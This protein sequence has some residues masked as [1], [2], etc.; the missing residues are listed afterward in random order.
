MRNFLLLAVLLICSSA[1]NAQQ[2]IAAE[3]Q[4]KIDRAKPGQLFPIW[5]LIQDQLD[6]AVWEAKFRDEKTSNSARTLQVINALKAQAAQSQTPIIAVIRKFAVAKGLKAYYVANLVAVQAPSSLIQALDQLPGI[7][8]IQSIP[9]DEL[10]PYEISRTKARKVSGVENGLNKIQAPFMWSLGYTGYGRKAFI[11]DTGTDPYHPALQEQY[12]GNQVPDA[13]AFYAKTKVP[14]PYDCDAHGSHV[15]GTIMGLDPVTHDTIGVAFEAKWMASPSLRVCLTNIGVDTTTSSLVD[16]FEWALDPDNNPNTIDDMPDAINN[17]WHNPFVPDGCEN[18]YKYVFNSLELA[19]VAVVFA[20][21]NEGPNAGTVTKPAMINTDLTNTFAVGALDG[22][23]DALPIADFSSHG[24]SPCPSNDLSLQIKPEVSAP[25][26]DVRSSIPGG[27]YDFYSGTSMASPHVCGAVV[28]LKQAFPDLPGSI[29]KEALYF[30]AL[31]LGVVGEDNTFGMGIIQLDKAY[32]YLIDHGNV[33][34]VI[35]AAQVD[36]QTFR[37]ASPQTTCNT[38]PRAELTIGNLGKGSV[39]C[40]IEWTLKEGDQILA[41]STEAAF[42]FEP[43]IMHFE[44]QFA[45][46]PPAI[47][48]LEA[49]LIVDDATDDRP[50]NNIIRTQI[51]IQPFEPINGEIYANP[52]GSICTTGSIALEVKPTDGISYVDWYNAP[53]AGTKLNSGN[54]ALFPV[55]TTAQTYYAEAHYKKFVGPDINS[56]GIT[57]YGNDS[58]GI[59]FHTHQAL[60][61][62]SVDIEVEATGIRSIILYR[63]AGKAVLNIKPILGLKVGINK[64]D[65]GFSLPD[66]GAYVLLLSSGKGLKF[67]TESVFPYSISDI[68]TMDNSIVKDQV[69]QQ[70]RYFYNWA[71]DYANPCGRAAYVVPAM[72]NSGNLLEMQISPPVGPYYPGSVLH[73]DAASD[74]SEYNWNLGDNSDEQGPFVTHSYSTTGN[75]P[76][77]L[78]RTQDS[79]VT[80]IQQNVLIEVNTGIKI[81]DNADIKVYPNPVADLL[82]VSGLPEGEKLLSWSMTN[83]LG[84]CLDKGQTAIKDQLLMI[85]TETLAPGFYV[86]NL[87]L[88]DSQYSVSFVK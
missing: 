73:F 3:L 12:W 78:C 60:I 16:A 20:N 85:G 50:L 28:L 13:Q 82:F 47:Y 11:I 86:L 38:H 8:Q 46:Y 66:T 49:K 87:L 43:G 41:N 54:P 35:V 72:Q 71:V 61:I 88:G 52:Q 62:K 37:L 17:S 57:E 68:L 33:A 23:K 10:T 44:Y 4:E 27:Q 24:P 65:L 51:N 79:C 64:V 76:V 15:T 63:K 18:G 80:C 19:G 36:V 34:Q 81:L 22:N 59:S 6:Y 14:F 9:T 40:H 77:I 58:A 29:I 32:Q 31:D 25:G 2:H 53:I 39:N 30:S 7:R 83:T 5:I 74:G 26:V 56:V 48:V 75:Y 84:Q 67:H 55:G 21:G 1:L 69:S 42:T 45:D 70:Y